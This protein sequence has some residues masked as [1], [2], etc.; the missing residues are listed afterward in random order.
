MLF[1]KHS[2]QISLLASAI[3]LTGCGSS[4]SDSDDDKGPGE[5]RAG[6]AFSEL[7]MSA[8]G[9]ASVLG[10]GGNGGDIDIYKT[11]SATKLNIVKQGNIDTSY[12]VPAQ[13]PEFGVNP[14]VIAATQT[15]TLVEDGVLPEAGTLYILPGTSRLFK[16]SGEKLV[17]DETHEVTGLTVNAGATLFLPVNSS[18]TASRLYFNNDI[19]N[20][21]VITTVN[22][23]IESR[24]DLR[25]TAAAYY[26][27]GAINLKGDTSNYYRQS[28]GDLSL[29]AYTI[30]NS[31][32]INT[33]G[34]NKSSDNT[35]GNG[36]GNAGTIQLNASIFIETTGELRANGG[37]SD[38]DSGTNGADISL[39]AAA[40]VNTGMINSNSGSGNNQSYN[41]NGSEIQ[42]NAAKSIVNTGIISSKGADAGDSGNAGKGG[43]IEIYLSENDEV[44]FNQSIINTGSLTV[45]GGSITGESDGNA[46]NAGNI[47]IYTESPDERSN[48]PVVFEIS[49]NLSANGGSTIEEDSNAGL[50]GQISIANYDNPSS[51]AETF[52]IG[53][54]E[55]N[56]SGGNGVDAGDAGSI[57]VDFDDFRKKLRSDARYVPTVS[58]SI[59]NNVDLIAN[60]GN[61]TAVAQA[62]GLD[63]IYG[64]GADGGNVVLNVAN[65]SAYLQPGAINIINEGS[66]TVNGGN[67]YKSSSR[68]NANGG[69]IRISA[70][71]KV[72]V[73]QP[74]ALNGGSDLHTATTGESDDHAG[75]NAGSLSVFSQYE[76][77]SIDTTVTANGGTGELVGGNGGFLNMTSKSAVT[78]N[79]SVS[80][81]GGNT[82]AND[83]DGFE[84]EGGDAGYV[85]AVAESM[86]SQVNATITANSGSGDKAGEEKV[87]YVDA[88][89]LSNNCQLDMGPR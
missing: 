70:A 17:G 26:G 48:A 27:A 76:N 16:S 34:A 38:S 49:G 36:G 45:D 22:D 73:S 35:T 65:Y 12:I 74:L 86:D 72:Q 75:S 41:S 52:I 29:S 2:L 21:G 79:G 40:I 61:T 30:I 1:N 6:T 67:S 5:G 31:G 24:I 62:A 15:I 81:N 68:S 54:N 53:Y 58:G 43:S 87:I 4:S 18:S 33:S 47:S 8:K 7:T 10:D 19:Q 28:G 84:T 50:G 71:H 82:V 44:A 3:A 55:I 32:L 85:Y 78:L 63:P 20:N 64:S 23:S 56:V 57:R 39:N 42:L 11:N 59:Y 25:L 60:G 46:G 13:T 14:V 9:G 80:L 88:D 51:S 69:E 37:H 89:C 66:I 77:V 83:A